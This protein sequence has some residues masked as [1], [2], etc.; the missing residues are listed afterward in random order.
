[1]TPNGARRPLTLSS[2]PPLPPGRWT[3]A[4]AARRGVN[5]W[6]VAAAALGRGGRLQRAQCRTDVRRA[7]SRT[8]QRLPPGHPPATAAAASAPPAARAAACAA[9]PPSH[10]GT[11]TRR[12]RASPPIDGFAGRAPSPIGLFDQSHGFARPT[13]ASQAREWTRVCNSRHSSRSLW[14]CGRVPEGQ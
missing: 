5:L 7:A 14:W 3:A 9:A 2:S 13:A 12:G 1:M 8:L 4:A 11:D 10:P 6:P